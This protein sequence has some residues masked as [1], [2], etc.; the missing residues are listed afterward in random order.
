[1]RVKYI[2]TKECSSDP[3]RPKMFPQTTPI[4][5]MT[6]FPREYFHHIYYIMPLITYQKM[7]GEGDVSWTLWP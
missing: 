4:C 5:I 2:T 7:E 3:M 1:M 6:N